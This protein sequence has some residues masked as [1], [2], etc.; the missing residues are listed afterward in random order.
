MSDH[1]SK[2]A[3]LLTELLRFIND[4]NYE[5]VGDAWSFGI[6]RGAS[7]SQAN[8]LEANQDEAVFQ[9]M[10]RLVYDHVARTVAIQRTSLASPPTVDSLADGFKKLMDELTP[11]TREALGQ[12]FAPIAAGQDAPAAE[13]V[14]VA[15]GQLDALDRYYSK[16]ILERLDG[17]VSRASA[18]DRMGLQKVPNQRVQFLFEEAH[19]CYLYGFHLACAVFCRAIL[20]AALKEV[21]DPGSETNQSIHE[22]IAAAVEKRLLTDVRP[23]CARE[24]AKAGNRA[25]HDPEMFARDYSPEKVERI[26]TDTRKVLAE[27]Y[28]LPS[29]D[30]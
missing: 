26:L 30:V 12:A 15:K 5:K 24:V 9:K 28:R 11:E 2:R 21:A 7:R 4:G 25:I 16:E 6:G 13:G 20:E 29:G 17:I 23:R 3:P 27:L 18:L 22:M 8:V 19:R 1:L 10:R 14:P